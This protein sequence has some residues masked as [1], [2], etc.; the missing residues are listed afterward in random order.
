MHVN[1]LLWLLLAGFLNTVG[2]ADF[3]LTKDKHFIEAPTVT[4][5]SGLAVSPT[6]GN[7]LWTVNDSGCTPELHLLE[8][9]GKDR[10]KITVSNAKNV[11]WEDLASFT[12]DGQAYLLIAD[13]GDNNGVRKNVSIHIVREPKLPVAGETL[14]GF[15]TAAWHI[16]FT[17]AGGPRDCEA[18]AVDAAKEKIILISKRT[19]PPEIYELPL[20][21]PKKRGVLTLTKIGTTSV[22]SPLGTLVPF[23]NQPTGLDISADRSLAAV[24]TYYGVFIFPR[25]PEETWADAFS[26]EPSSL[27]P[28][29]MVQ[30]ESIAFSKDGKSLYVTSEGKSQAILRYQQ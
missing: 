3:S 9:N 25:K 24:V 6:T 7:F 23:A 14:N 22:P 20:R 19:H 13:T 17:Y 5:A 4:E 18:V 11:D 28:H 2:A 27:G 26:R 29:G 1:P 8:T 21:A 16:D 10:G 15:T 12:L 30:A